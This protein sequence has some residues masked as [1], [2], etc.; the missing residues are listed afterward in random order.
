M[1]AW[2]IV[3]KELR[4]AL[5]DRRS[6]MSGLFYGVWGPMVMGAALV[7]LAGQH[8]DLGDVTIAA[9]GP[10]QAPSLVAYLETR[11]IHVQNEAAVSEED[12]R[13]HRRP[14][15]LVVDDGYSGQFAESRPAT[16]ALLH[17]S[18]WPE[19]A[20]LTSHVRGALSDYAR[21][22]G[23]TR[24]V[25]RGVAPA[26]IAGI[27]IVG[28]DFSTAAGRAGRMLATMPIF[29]LL[30]AF[31]GGMSVTADVTAGER[32]TLESLLLHPVGRFDIT[33]GKWL[34]ISGIALLTVAVA[35]A[36]SFA[37]LQ[38]PRLQALDIPIG[39]TGADALMMFAIL[40]PLAV[41]ASA[42]QLFMAMQAQT[43]KEAQTKLSMLIFLPMIPGFLFA[44]GTLQPAP[45]MAY[46]P[47]LGQ[48][49]LITAV[50]RGDIVPV[51]ATIVLSAITLAA[52]VAAWFAAARQLQ[53]ESILRRIR[54]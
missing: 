44:F 17:D 5:R 3:R 37:V 21:S 2:W 18:T 48:H 46:A 53:R 31:I 39:L 34:A 11:R 43:F 36:V 26:A 15:V 42:V 19:S 7:G 29:V 32:G 6:L 9:R 24:L 12:V 49:M 28:R 1:R 50:V 51:P 4:E 41:A 38:H 8:A 22:V 20:R 45:W 52:G 16:V 10:E 30:A 35:L 23:D 33:G 27:R 13:S 54:A 40:A 14:L 25:L 47:M